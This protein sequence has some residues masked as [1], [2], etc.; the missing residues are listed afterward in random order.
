MPRVAAGGPEL[1]PVVGGQGL[2]CVHVHQLPGEGRLGERD[3]VV[4]VANKLGP[5]R[6]ILSH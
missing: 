6:I 2:T 4:G 5:E 1:G 3:L